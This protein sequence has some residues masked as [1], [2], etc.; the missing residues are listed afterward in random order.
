VDK[1]R[2]R[3]Y[4]EEQGLAEILP[5]LIG[6]GYNSP[7]EISLEWERL[8]NQFVIKYNHG[9][10]YNILVNDKHE[11]NSDAIVEQL[12]K[13]SKEDYWKIYG[14]TQYKFIEKKII[15]EEYLGDDIQSYKFLCFNGRPEVLYVSDMGYLDF[16][17][18]DW[19]WLPISLGTHD[20]ASKPISK[21]K[22]LLRMIDIAKKLSSNFP[23]VRVDLYNINDK[24]YFSE[25]TFIPTGGVMKLNP[26]EIAIEWGEKI[27]LK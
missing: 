3:A 12:H 18:L 24:I 14:E 7:E 6:G 15:I 4:V 25:L 22:N 5:V 26:P 23:F 9:C 13:W 20:H 19:N 1:Y 8:P 21:P 27:Q 10:G 17:D 11:F 2:A 16:F